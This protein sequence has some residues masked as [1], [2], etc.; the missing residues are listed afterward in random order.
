MNIPSNLNIT[1]GGS[2]FIIPLPKG[3]NT[4]NNGISTSSNS[5]QVQFTQTNGTLLGSANVTVPANGK[6]GSVTFDARFG[7]PPIKIPAVRT[8]PI[9]PIVLPTFNVPNVRVRIVA[10]PVK[11]QTAPPPPKRLRIQSS[12]KSNAFGNAGGSLSS[13]SKRNRFKVGRMLEETEPTFDVQDQQMFNNL[14]KGVF[15]ESSAV[16]HAA[17]SNLPITNETMDAAALVAGAKEALS[18]ANVLASTMQ[19]TFDGVTSS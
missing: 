3:S 1:L 14:V 12:S 5:F 9:P 16:A 17:A 10:V 4:T 11:S 6:I 18:A 8:I 13:G 7:V 2:T 15:D 19:H